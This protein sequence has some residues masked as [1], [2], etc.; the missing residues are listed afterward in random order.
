MRGLMGEEEIT[1]EN[2][3][4]S[5][6]MKRFY[7]CCATE[8]LTPE[9]VSA[10]CQERAKQPDAIGPAN[11][12]VRGIFRE[13]I[14]TI[15]PHT[16]LE[17]GAGCNPILANDDPIVSRVRYIKSDADINSADGLTVFSE[18][19]CRLNYPS[20]HFELA[21]AV[22]VLHFNFYENQISE[23]YRCLSADGAFVANIYRR[24][25]G[26]RAA[27]AE[28][29]TRN[30]FFIERLP[31]PYVAC[32]NHEYWIFVKKEEMLGTYREKL[33]KALA[34]ANCV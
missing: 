1:Y 14:L 27:L 12:Q 32:D 4:F 18:K 20:G 11:A 31:D 3:R 8:E 29:F 7:V 26:S 13:L 6:F 24:T 10:L 34:G 30:G 2:Q 23:L 25:E 33:L 21:A 16:F 22:F 19:D 28:N 15:N 5:R 9:E 17:V